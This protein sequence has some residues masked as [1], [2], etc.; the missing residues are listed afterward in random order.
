MKMMKENRGL[1]LVELLITIA[2]LSIVV[3]SA[4]S[5]MITGSKSFTKG[6]ADSEL[7]RE[8]ELTVNQVEDM[9][10]D[11]NGGLTVEYEYENPGAGEGEDKGAVT[12][13]ELTMYHAEKETDATGAEVLDYV[14]ESVVW[15]PAGG[16]DVKDKIYY[17]KW[18]VSYDSDSGSFVTEGAPIADNQLLAERVSLFEVDTDTEDEMAADGTVNTIVRS[19]QVRVGYENSF[20]RVEYATSP[21]ITLRNRMLLSADP[22]MLFEVPEKVDANFRLYY[23][24][25]DG[26]TDVP[27]VTPIIDRSSTVQRG[28]RYQIYAN[29]TNGNTDISDLVNW[30]IEESGTCFSSID[31][32]SGKLNVDPNEP[33]EYLSV[34]ATYKSNPAKK[35]TGVLKV[36]GG[37]GKSFKAIKIITLSLN[38]NDKEIANISAYYG[39]YPTFTGSW[40]QE[41]MKALTY[42]WEIM[43]HSDWV[44]PIIDNQE[45]LTFKV[46]PEIAKL[47]EGEFI[48]IKLTATSDVT[49]EIR[50][51]TI[52][53]RIVRDIYGGDSFM[54][55]GM[56][57]SEESSKDGDDRINFWFDTNEDFD[58]DILMDELEY[59]FCDVNGNRISEYDPLL[60]YVRLHC[61]FVKTYNHHFYYTLTYD[62]ALPF[63]HEYYVMVV[64]HMIDPN[65]GTTRQYKRMFYIPAVSLYDCYEYY[66][67][68]NGYF[69]FKFGMVGYDNVAL[70]TANPLDVVG[71]E[72]T[73]IDY[74]IVRTQENDPWNGKPDIDLSQVKVGVKYSQSNATGLHK[75]S[76]MKTEGNVYIQNGDL[77]YLPYYYS[78]K[79]NSLTTKVYMKEYPD[80]YTYVTIYCN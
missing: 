67:Q 79:V 22:N 34:T 74:E 60:P 69:S 47:H 78:F 13:T 66:L 57:V 19:V 41:E 59:Y 62:K 23:E 14:K 28:S 42:K 15:N 11:T 58:H 53:Y 64:A 21:I 18:N 9:V 6:N 38:P 73:D 50:N 16:D 40:T 49:G 27:L 12:R 17:S 39:S 68:S 44:E 80:I 65:D 3:T 71:F 30:K 75:L 70:G 1:T 48:D 76:E 24:S 8:A 51:D 61:E 25:A 56:G 77:N 45:T 20:G 31:A 36:E 32:A 5:F 63:N 4:T 46:K 43:N 55:R 33:C 7:Q 10:I 52:R 29:L 2:I 54:R 72:V 37:S 35:A 26:G